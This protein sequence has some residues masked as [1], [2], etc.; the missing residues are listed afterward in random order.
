MN[1]RPIYLPCVGNLFIH[2]F[3]P[4]NFGREICSRCYRLK[5]ELGYR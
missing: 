1:V 5:T 4:D 3:K 2:V